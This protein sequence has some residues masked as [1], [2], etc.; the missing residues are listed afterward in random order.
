MAEHEV[1]HR[2]AAT[3]AA[4]AT[5]PRIGDLFPELLE[6]DHIESVMAAAKTKPAA[7]KSPAAETKPAAKKSPASKTKT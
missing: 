7:K 6:I 3:I 5:D 1:G 2:A 4:L